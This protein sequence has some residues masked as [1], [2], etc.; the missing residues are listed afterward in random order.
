VGAG[1]VAFGAGSN[2][3]D[4]KEISPDALRSIHSS[5]SDAIAER[6]NAT[7]AASRGD[8]RDAVDQEEVRAAEA[9]T[10]IWRLPL[11]N[12][13]FTSAYGV[14]WGKLHAG[15]DLAAP[16][17][18]VYRAIHAGEVTQAGYYGGYGYAITIRQAD[19][20]EIIYAHSRR[21]FVKVG[22]Q[23]KAAQPI[24][25]VGNTGASY[26]THLHIE[27][28]VKGGPTDPIPFLRDNGVDLKLQVESVYA[29]L[30]NAS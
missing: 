23:V 6:D 12:Y 15:V 14:R 16:E 2:L 11:E 7:K 24:G 17:G 13:T 4:A 8:S 25:Q 22:D 28:H 30:A 18:T 1:V 26:G 20:T 3:P 27:V 9:S 21:L 10:D 19:G 29:G 5:T